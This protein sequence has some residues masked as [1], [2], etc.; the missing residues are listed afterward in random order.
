M[1]EAG[2]DKLVGNRATLTKRANAMS[3]VVD[4]QK[5]IPPT[6][7]RTKTTTEADK[8]A[9]KVAIERGEEVSGVHM[10]QSISLIRK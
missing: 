4:D 8:V 7:L 9:I 2:L 6:F 5:L 10:V 3:L 1:S